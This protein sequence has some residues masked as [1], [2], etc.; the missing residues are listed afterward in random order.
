MGVPAATWKPE[1]TTKANFY[2]LDTFFPLKKSA[3]IMV[4]FF[5]DTKENINPETKN[6]NQY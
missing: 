4:T 5:G 2:I 3:V 6:L 1:T